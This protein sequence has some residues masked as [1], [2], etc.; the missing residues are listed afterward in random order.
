MI[1]IDS[2]T[3]PAEIIAEATRP[4]LG[5]PEELARAAAELRIEGT[6]A[7]DPGPDLCRYSLVGPDGQVLRHVDVPGW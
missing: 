2:I 7:M 4:R 1:L 6:S 3:D 5:F